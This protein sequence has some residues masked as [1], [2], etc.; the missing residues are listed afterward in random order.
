VVNAAYRVTTQ[1]RPSGGTASL[2]GLM[3][4]LEPAFASAFG[5]AIVATCAS[6][7][8]VY[9]LMKPPCAANGNSI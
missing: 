7:G 5:R 4:I 9:F 2:R 3:P 1:A 6:P 8:G